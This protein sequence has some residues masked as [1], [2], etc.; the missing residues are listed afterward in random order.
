[1]EDGETNRKLISVDADAGGA[2]VATAENGTDRRYDWPTQEPF[3]LMLMDMQ[4]PV[5]DGYTAT[6][7]CATAASRA[8]HRAD[9]ARHEGRP[10]KVRAAGCSG[11]LTKPI[12]M[13][14]WWPPL[15]KLRRG[16]GCLHWPTVIA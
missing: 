10:G 14:S 2:N 3:D 6:R 11:Y 5:M 15:P 12:N 16:Y 9:G 7:A 4:M 1:M 13:D 8:D